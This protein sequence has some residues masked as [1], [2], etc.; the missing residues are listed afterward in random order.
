MPH[1]YIQTNKFYTTP[2]YEDYHLAKKGHLQ[3]IDP[4]YDTKQTGA[5]WPLVIGQ[6]SASLNQQHMPDGVQVEAFQ[7]AL[8]KFKIKREGTSVSHFNLSLT[9]CVNYFEEFTFLYN[10]TDPLYKLTDAAK[11]DLLQS[12]HEAMDKCETGLNGRLYTALQAHQKESDWIQNELVKARC[13]T[14]RILHN[15]SGSQDVHAYN[16]L[17]QMANNADLGIPKKE[18]I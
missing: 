16:T 9:Q 6:L 12:I 7:R 14:L 13:E 17:V 15:Q 18:E 3:A 8:A 11:K 10:T 2:R 4:Q 1:V 5:K